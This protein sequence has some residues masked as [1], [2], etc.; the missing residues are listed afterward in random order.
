MSNNGKL[1]DVSLLYH[2][3]KE[4]ATIAKKEQKKFTRLGDLQAAS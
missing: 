4:S 1:S 2:R 3:K